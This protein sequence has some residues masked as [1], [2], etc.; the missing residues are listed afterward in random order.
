MFGTVCR[1]ACCWRSLSHKLPSW[2][3]EWATTFKSKGM[4]QHS[5]FGF[6]VFLPFRTSEEGWC[7]LRM[8]EWFEDWEDGLYT[9]GELQIYVKDISEVED[10][11][12]LSTLYRRLWIKSKI[13]ERYGKEHVNFTKICGRRDVVCFCKMTN[14]TINDKWNSDKQSSMQWRGECSYCRMC[15]QIDQRQNLWRSISYQQVSNLAIDSWLGYDTV[16]G[17]TYAKT[18]YGKLDC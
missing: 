14:H 7:F 2:V 15:H 9:L 18:F 8:F 4:I 17:A 1:F 12:T 6:F 10:R 11:T 3:H 5:W 16:M 13:I